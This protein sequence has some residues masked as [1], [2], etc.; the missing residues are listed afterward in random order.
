MRDMTMGAGEDLV[1]HFSKGQ[2]AKGQLSQA[3]ISKNGAGYSYASVADTFFWGE[4]RQYLPYFQGVKL[5]S[6][7]Q[8]DALS[9]GLR[10]AGGT[11]ALK[12]D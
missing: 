4:K 1:L 6:G 8:Q 9:N 5:K 12:E 11:G 10:V 2:A 7:S 3:Q